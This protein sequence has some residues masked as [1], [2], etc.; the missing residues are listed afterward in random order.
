MER[1]YIF[2][3]EQTKVQCS[4][5]GELISIPN[6]LTVND[7]SLIHDFVIN[8]IG[9]VPPKCKIILDLDAADPSL[10]LVIALHIRLSITEIKERTLA[11]ILLVSNFPLQSFLTLGECSQFFLSQSGYAFTTPNNVLPAIEAVQGISADKYTTEFLSQIQIRPDEGLNHSLANEWGASVLDR[12][13]NKGVPSGYPT[14]N[15]EIKKLYFKYVYAQTINVAEYLS[16]KQQARYYVQNRAAINGEGKR[17]LL[18]DDEADK[19]WAYVLKQL[20]VTN[21]GD[22][23]VISHKAKSYDDFTKE[24][25]AQ[26]ENGDYDLIFLD[27]RMNGAEEENVYRPDDFSGMNIL[28]KIKEKQ[29]GVQIIMFTASNKAWNLKALLDAGADG[30]YI[31]ES[32]EYKFSLNFS[33]ANYD[34]LRENIEYCLQ[35]TYL[36]KVDAQIKAIRKDFNKTHGDNTNFKNSI[37]NQME[38]SYNLLNEQRFAYAFISLYQVIELINDYYLDRDANNVWYIKETDEDAMS[39]ST[40]NFRHE[41]VEAEFTEDDKRKFPEWKKLACLYYQLWKQEDKSF[42]Y[43]VQSL[44]NERNKFM[45]NEADKK[46]KI[47]TENGYLELLDIIVTVCNF[48]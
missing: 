40:Q 43:K 1:I 31:K 7:H 24:E 10:V 8:N 42:G 35:R 17:I 26:I 47:Y 12:L 41:C 6:K 5:I 38:L 32:P 30:Y 15:S 2:G 18:I 34:A 14:L 21:E 25:H 11:P 23:N 27:L 19:G 39:W 20:I 16:G 22:F 37:I 4:Q 29:R 48:V 46:S 28:K 13:I 33:I 44:I 36:K 9:Y 45:H 3:N